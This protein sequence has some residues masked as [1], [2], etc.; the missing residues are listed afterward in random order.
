[1]HVD[2]MKQCTRVKA[3]KHTIMITDVMTFETRP[4]DEVIEW[5]CDNNIWDWE[6]IAEDDGDHGP[7]Y[8]YYFVNPQDAVLFSLRWS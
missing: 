2:V 5:T 4:L 1:M 6:L 8:V 3:P 7:L